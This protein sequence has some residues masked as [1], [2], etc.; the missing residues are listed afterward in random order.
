MFIYFSSN[1]ISSLGIV[2]RDFT[3]T[4]VQIRNI[5]SN[6]GIPRDSLLKLTVRA[7]ACV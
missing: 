7:E 3:I 6:K 5:R 1:L 2:R 4:K